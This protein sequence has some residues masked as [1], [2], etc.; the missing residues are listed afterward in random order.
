MRITFQIGSA[1]STNYST[2]LSQLAKMINKMR[3]PD[4]SL[5]TG[6]VECRKS[7]TG[8]NNSEDKISNL[9]RPTLIDTEIM[10]DPTKE[11]K[12]VFPN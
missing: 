1:R 9:S 4:Q 2:R 10:K 5:T 3:D 11:E 7:R 12:K 8:V 6:V